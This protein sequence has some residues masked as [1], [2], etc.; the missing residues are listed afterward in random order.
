MNP[1]LMASEHH[2]PKG[3]PVLDAV[4]RSCWGVGLK[5]LL[6]FALV[7]EQEARWSKAG[8]KDLSE[9]VPL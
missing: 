4:C 2:L 1:L 9:Q 5:E 8:R 7:T 3:L 6:H